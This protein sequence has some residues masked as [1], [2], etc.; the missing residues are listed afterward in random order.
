LKFDFK[1][2]PK[3]TKCRDHRAVSFVA[4]TAKRVA[5]NLRRKFESKF[6]NVLAKDQFGFRRGK[7]N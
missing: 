5:R 1:K 3:A 6:D 2:K 4:H 7:G